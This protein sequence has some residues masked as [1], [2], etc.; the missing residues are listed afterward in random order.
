[1]DL[2]GSGPRLRETPSQYLPGGTEEK[3]ENVQSGPTEVQ[4]EQLDSTSLV[5]PLL[6]SSL[7]KRS[8]KKAPFMLA[9]LLLWQAAYCA[10]KVPWF[11][12]WQKQ[13]SDHPLIQWAS[14]LSHCGKVVGA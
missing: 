13:G 7:I 6:V 3:H 2:E 4:S 11:D 10:V 5:L 12:S 1:M 14:G 8:L 9:K